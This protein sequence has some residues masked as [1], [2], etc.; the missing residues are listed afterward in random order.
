MHFPA[1]KLKWPT[2]RYSPSQGC[3]PLPPI[4]YKAVALNQGWCCPPGNIWQCF[5]TFLVVLRWGVAPG[6]QW[7]LMLNMLQGTR[8][9]LDTEWSS[10]NVNSWEVEELHS[11]RQN[12]PGWGPPDPGWGLGWVGVTTL[13]LPWAIAAAPGSGCGGT[14]VGVWGPSGQGSHLASSFKL[15]NL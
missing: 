14:W 2:D 15:L 6:I 11:R 4:I 10:P 9:P 5:K 12:A 8:E 13:N 1:S 7:V 3:L